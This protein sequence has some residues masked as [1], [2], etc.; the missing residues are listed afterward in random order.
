MCTCSLML[1]S[2]EASKT[3]KPESPHLLPRRAIAV[4]TTA[5]IKPASMRLLRIAGACA[6]ARDGGYRPSQ[7]ERCA[8]PQVRFDLNKGWHPSSP[9]A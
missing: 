4:N 3:C 2:S 9:S 7:P 8:P 5:T 6:S 1:K